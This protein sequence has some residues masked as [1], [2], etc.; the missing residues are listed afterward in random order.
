[1]AAFKDN[2]NVEIVGAKR[3]KLSLSYGKTHAAQAERGAAT[4]PDQ[5]LRRIVAAMIG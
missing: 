1:M 5:E 3:P 2:M 4:L